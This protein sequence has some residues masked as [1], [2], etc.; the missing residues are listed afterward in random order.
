M[1]MEVKIK[2]EPAWLEG[3][4]SASLENIEHVS[5]IILLKKEAKSELTEP[6]PTQENSFEPSENFKKEIFIEEHTDDQLLSYIKEETKSFLIYIAT[7]PPA[8]PVRSFR[9]KV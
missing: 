5:E 6:G 3:A 1:D 9:I 7:P 8:L 2:E 4:T